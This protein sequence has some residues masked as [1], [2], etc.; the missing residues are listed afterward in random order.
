L[1]DFIDAGPGDYIFVAT[2]YAKQFASSEQL[3]LA[4]VME[5]KYGKIWNGEGWVKTS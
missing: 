1:V 3:W 2:D 5:E 4:F